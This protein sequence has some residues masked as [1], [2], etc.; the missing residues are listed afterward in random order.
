[1]EL[2]WRGSEGVR[3]LVT[4]L[5]VKEEE[6]LGSQMQTDTENGAQASNYGGITRE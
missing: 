6:R 4:K 2:K 3:S 1:M 5:S